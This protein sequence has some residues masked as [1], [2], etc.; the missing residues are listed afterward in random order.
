M[1]KILAFAGS[2]SSTSINHELVLCAVQKLQYSTG[3]VI[4][5]TDYPLPMFG[6]DIE[7]ELGSPNVLKELLLKIKEAD[8][9]MLSVNEH[10]SSVSAFFKNVIDWLSRVEY[11]CLHGKKVFLMST[12]NGKRGGQSAHEYTQGVL[13][14]LDAEEVFNF[15]LPSYSE[16]FKDGEIINNE[17]RIELETQLAAFE[18]A[19]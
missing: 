7:R 9:V 14:R 11:K 4:R 5:L 6:E 3:H 15:T 19:L 1:K 16:N 13:P 8:A 2:N 10:N 18:A 17:L 12:S